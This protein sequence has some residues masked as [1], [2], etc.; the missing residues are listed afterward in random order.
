MSGTAAGPSGGRETETVVVSVVRE[1][2]GAGLE[3]PRLA[4]SGAAGADVCAAVPEGVPLVLVPGAWALVPTGLRLAIPSGFEVQVRPR[5][6]LALKHGVTVLNAPGTIDSDYRGE[7]GILLV[8]HGPRPF[9]VTRG[10]RVAQL[11]L[12]RTWQATYVDVASLDGT[13]RGDGGFGSTGQ[14]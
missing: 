10:M 6:G 11:V 8:N 7:L 5:S 3:L 14:E 9:T 4:T 13:A 2:H 12:A 1:P